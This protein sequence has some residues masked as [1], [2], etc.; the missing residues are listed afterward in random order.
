MD[1]LSELRTLRRER[2]FGEGLAL[3]ERLLREGSSSAELLVFRAQM[4]QLAPATDMP[5]PLAAAEES[6]A[7]ACALAPDAVEPRIEM[8]HFLYAV[9]DRPA[10]ALTQFEAAE[11]LARAGL[12]DALIGKIK[13]LAQLGRQSE[14]RAEMAT[15]AEMFPDDTDLG[16]LQA[17]LEDVG[18]E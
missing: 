17:E 7:Q 15:A 11:R 10:D 3:V 16:V 4:L 12:K 8:G 9:K 6:L 14:A 13:C 18:E 1:A 5:D 2:R